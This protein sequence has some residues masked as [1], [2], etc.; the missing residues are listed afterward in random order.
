[1]RILHAPG[2]VLV[3]PVGEGEPEDD[4]EEQRQVPND[5][6]CARVEEVVDAADQCALC[7]HRSSFPIIHPAANAIPTNA[8]S[9][10]AA[11]A[12]TVSLSPTWAMVGLR[13]GRRRGPPAGRASP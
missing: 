4:D 10:S 9:N 2:R 7:D 12:N 3:D 5:E 6:P 13:I 11:N 8:A 1:P